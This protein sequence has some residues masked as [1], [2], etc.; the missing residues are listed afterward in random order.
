MHGRAGDPIPQGVGT[1]EL[2]AGAGEAIGGIDRRQL[3]IP[4]GDDAGIGVIDRRKL[5]P[6][7]PDA[8]PLEDVVDLVQLD[9]IVPQG[10]RG[11]HAI[12][13][14]QVDLK[15]AACDAASAAIPKK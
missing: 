10:E 2:R 8:V 5:Q 15:T 13:A 9:Q 6:A 12:E 1:L 7:F 11:R 3:V 14:S 4:Q